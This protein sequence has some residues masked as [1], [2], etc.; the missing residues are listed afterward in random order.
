MGSDPVLTAEKY[1]GTGSTPNAKVSGSDAAAGTPDVSRVGTTAKVPLLTACVPAPRPPSPAEAGEAWVE[2]AT[3]M[4]RRTAAVAPVLPGISLPIIR[5][6]LSYQLSVVV[7]ARCASSN[8]KV[9]VVDRFWIVPPGSV[10]F[11]VV[12][13]WSGSVVVIL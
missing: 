11:V 8:V 5:R 1:C 2:A 4:P 10:P 7:A 12:S 9:S 3:S 6:E 13:A